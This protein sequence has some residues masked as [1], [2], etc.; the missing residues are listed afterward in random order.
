MSQSFMII[1]DQILI[2]ED[3][4]EPPEEDSLVV[5]DWHST[6]LGD[7]Q[8]DPPKQPKNPTHGMPL[9]KL[10]FGEEVCSAYKEQL[11]QHNLPGRP[12]Y[13]GTLYLTNY[14][15]YFQ[16]ESKFGVTQLTPPE[17]RY[18]TVPYG[19]ISTVEEKTTHQV[20]YLIVV[21]LKDY[22]CLKFSLKD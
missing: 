15:L 3:S 12:D 8:L 10:E 9:Q 11:C 16:P 2:V 19:F 5:S 4:D 21:T 22:L 14:K 17:D 1:E 13:T 7:K 6:A 20:A 18:F